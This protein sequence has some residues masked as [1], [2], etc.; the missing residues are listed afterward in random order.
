VY[1]GITDLVI[2]HPVKVGVVRRMQR[3]QHF[4]PLAI[5]KIGLG[6]FL[7]VVGGD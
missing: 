5:E 6:I 2:H 3:V 7:K 1:I 4:H